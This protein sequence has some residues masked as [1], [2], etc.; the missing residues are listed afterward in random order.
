[1][2]VSFPK[3][4]PLKN[5]FSSETFFVL[6]ILHKK[7]RS[8]SPLHPIYTGKGCPSGQICMKG[9]VS[10]CIPLGHFEDTPIWVWVKKNR[11]DSMI[12]S[13]IETP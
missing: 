4:A 7:A 1:M 13:S 11:L 2:T 5:L 6:F 8:E 3:E 9:P 10:G 12:D